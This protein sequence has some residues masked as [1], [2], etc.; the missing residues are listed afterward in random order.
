MQTDERR[1]AWLSRLATACA[2]VAAAIGFLC[3]LGWIFDVGYLTEL[4]PGQR[5]MVANTAIGL[6]LLAGSLW[7]V[8][9]RERT[10]DEARAWSRFL[11][12]LVVLLGAVTLFEHIF[13]TDL[14]IDDWLGD[15]SGGADPGRMSPHAA[16]ALVSIGLWLA[17]LDRRGPRWKDA[18]DVLAALSALIAFAGLLA[19]LYGADYIYGDPG[20]TGL[21][22]QSV[23]GLVALVIGIQA[24]RPEGPWMRLLLAPGAG[25]HMMRRLI[26]ALV[27]IPTAAGAVLIAGVEN[28]WFTVQTGAAF[29]IAASVALLLTV[30]A[31]TSLE[32]EGAEAERF[33]MQRKLAELVDRDPL[34]DVFNRRRL[35]DELRR[36]LA[37]AQRT[38]SCLAVISIDLD[39]FKA[40]NDSF[41]HATGDALLVATADVLRQE[42]RA[43]DFIC[44]TGGDE[45]L[46]LLAD[47]SAEAARVVAEKL[48]RGFRGVTRPR[49]GGGTVALRASVGLALSEASGWSEP[50]D[51]LAAAD[52]ALYAAKQ[53][54]GDR[55][56]VDETAV[57]G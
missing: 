12:E 36:Q 48:V 30:L 54:G 28:D 55:L 39:E 52:V 5:A 42:L 23:V 45:F 46:V 29:A 14:G 32:L 25:G 10:T 27:A 50:D 53:A 38:G 1:S 41:G 57:P 43:S 20:E 26:P 56:A 2:L 11:G 4:I 51:L 22:L 15:E 49:P 13:S 34:T 6:L 3:L 31:Y 16:A 44:R 7:L 17:I 21:A 37:L 8:R 35:D 40:T 33:Q 9:D 47:T 19:A 18:G 24:A